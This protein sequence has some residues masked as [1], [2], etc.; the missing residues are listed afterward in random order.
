ML[1]EARKPVT[2]SVI[3]YP[4]SSLLYPTSISSL[5]KIP[6]HVSLKIRQRGIFQYLR[7][8]RKLNKPIFKRILHQLII[9]LSNVSLHIL[10]FRYRVLKFVQ[11][12]LAITKH[13]CN[14][15]CR[16]LLR[17]YNTANTLASYTPS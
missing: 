13:C 8:L 7:D 11:S 9:V 4:V 15:F 16:P 6:F 17:Q 10:V 12:F 5:F 1:A 2:G 14:S 3:Q